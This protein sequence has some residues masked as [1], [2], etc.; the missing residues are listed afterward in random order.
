MKQNV[1]VQGFNNSIQQHE[2][3]YKYFIDELNYKLKQNTFLINGSEVIE[4]IAYTL[5]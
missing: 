3:I 2:L 1:I 4:I 5:R